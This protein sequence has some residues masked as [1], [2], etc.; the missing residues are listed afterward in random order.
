M[1][2][3]S[4]GSFFACSNW[5]P[6]LGRG[7]I[8]LSKVKQNLFFIIC[9]SYLKFH[10]SILNRIFPLSIGVI[11][12]KIYYSY[13]MGIKKELG[14]RIRNIRLMQS[15]TQE[16][17][18]EKLGISPK[19]LSQIECGNNFVSAET[20]ETLCKTLEIAPKTLFDFNYGNKNTDLLCDINTRLKNNPIVLQTVHKITV[21]LDEN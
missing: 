5:C 15:L 7:K 21:A 14:N 17:L 8:F 11:L 20:L 13:Y 2:A 12:L 4:Q 6:S 19:T 18:A 3:V 10:N 9:F 16:M 1:H